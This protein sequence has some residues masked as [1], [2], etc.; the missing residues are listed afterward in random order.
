MAITCASCASMLPLVIAG[1]DQVRAS[2][3]ASR[4][5]ATG[6][7]SRAVSCS[8]R[9]RRES[10][11]P[12]CSTRLPRGDPTRTFVALLAERAP[13]PP[14]HRTAHAPALGRRERSIAA[15]ART[16]HDDVVEIAP[17]TWLRACN[18][19]RPRRWRARGRRRA[20]EARAARPRA[21]A[22]DAP[23]YVARVAGADRCRRRRH[24]RGR[25]FSRGHRRRCRDL[26][27][28]TRTTGRDRRTRARSRRAL[29][30]AL[31]TA[32]AHGLTEFAARAELDAARPLRRRGRSWPT[33]GAKDERSRSAI[34]GSMHRMVAA[35]QSTAVDHLGRMVG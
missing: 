5:S 3:A 20:R 8:T 14:S 31:A 30:S 33:C 32:G 35:A 25:A 19:R 11:C 2:G 18:A 6:A 29:A 1:G 27:A 22:R 23:R 12:R 26:R 15:A 13:H 16:A 34:C 21:A 28:A 9:R 7:S 4:Q 10:A 17:A 24:A